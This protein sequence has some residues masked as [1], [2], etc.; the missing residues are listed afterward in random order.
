[1]TVNIAVSKDGKKA[2]THVNGVRCITE[3]DFRRELK[4]ISEAELS[5]ALYSLMRM[6]YVIESE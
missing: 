1:M 5:A 2:V 3:D 6:Q 4:D